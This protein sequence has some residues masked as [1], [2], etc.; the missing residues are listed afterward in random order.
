M[1]LKVAPL[2][3][4]IK[5]LGVE[6][7]NQIWRNVKLRATGMKRARGLLEVAE[8]N[9]ESQE[10]PNGTRIELNHLLYDYEM[11]QKKDKKADG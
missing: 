7:I 6:G 3:Q 2:Q 4:D 1:V 5:K 10:A 9:I 8:H 11:Y